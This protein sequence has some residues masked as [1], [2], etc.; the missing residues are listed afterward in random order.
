MS[1][2]PSFLPFPGTAAQTLPSVPQDSAASDIPKSTTT[3]V[4]S[5]TATGPTPFVSGTS[6]TSRAIRSLS[7][8]VASRLSF[9]LAGLARGTPSLESAEGWR[10]NGADSGPRSSGYLL[11]HVHDSVSG[12]MSPVCSQLMLDGTSSDA[13]AT[14]PRFGTLVSG[15]L[16]QQPMLER[17]IEGIA[18][19]SSASMN[20]P[21]ARAEDAEQVRPSPARRALG[22]ADTLTAAV[23]KDWPTATARDYKGARSPEAMALTGRNPMTN[24]LSDA[25]E[26]GPPPPASGP[27]DPV[28]LSTSGNQAEWYTPNVPNGGRS[29]PAD[30]TGT[31]MTPK[32]KRQVG[33]HNQMKT[34][35]SGKLSPAWVETLMGVPMG[36][37]QL[38]HKF[39]KPKKG[40]P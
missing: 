13:L 27:P 16:Y 9:L 22:V 10:M 4:P 2:Q 31:G 39:V 18:S 11:T 26:I 33:L 28:K 6:E 23:Q 15:K 12:R 38:P 20:W 29:M 37:T 34:Q 35:A 5:I 8:Q 19:G 7:A 14:W 25:V 24:N 21:T 36:H 30:S 40:T 3:P 1:D 17:H 32:G